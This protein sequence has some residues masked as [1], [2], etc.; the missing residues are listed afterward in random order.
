[1]PYWTK[2]EMSVIQVTILLILYHPLLS[3]LHQQVGGNQLYA[4]ISM[5]LPIE[6]L[7]MH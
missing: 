5:H 7:R 6:W 1:M 3:V 2:L 4:G